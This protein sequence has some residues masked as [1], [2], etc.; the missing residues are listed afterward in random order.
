MDINEQIFN[1]V[2]QWGYARDKAQADAALRRIA[3]LTGCARLTSDPLTEEQ[4][5]SVMQWLQENYPTAY[6]WALGK[7]WAG[8][9]AIVWGAGGSHTGQPRWLGDRV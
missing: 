2:Q 6:L 9:P 7:Q 1:L 3:S 4:V 8:H 5:N